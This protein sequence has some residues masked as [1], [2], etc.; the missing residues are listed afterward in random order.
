MEHSNYR[1]SFVSPFLGIV[2]HGSHRKR[3]QE[4][5]FNS[6]VDDRVAAADKCVH[7]DEKCSGQ[8]N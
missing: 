5:F 8:K 4:F 7:D 6:A 3:C 1:S 2:S